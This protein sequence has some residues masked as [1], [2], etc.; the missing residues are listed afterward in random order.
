MK[1][2]DEATSAVLEMLEH[3]VD[4][5]KLVKSVYFDIDNLERANLM[6]PKLYLSAGR[7]KA[8]AA[9]RRSRLERQLEK[10]MAEKSL[11]IRRTKQ[12]RDAKRD[13]TEGV[14]KNYLAVDPEIRRAKRKL[15]EAEVVEEF[16]KHLVETFKERLMILALLTKLQVSELASELRQAQGKKAVTTLSEKAKEVRKRMADMEELDDE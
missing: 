14:V 13:L 1:T 16:A 6:Q 12:R 3:Q 5:R 8:E 4:L 10:I 11:V 7:F 9:L 15:S 2:H